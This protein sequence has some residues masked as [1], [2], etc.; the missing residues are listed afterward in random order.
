MKNEC[1]NPVI[2]KENNEYTKPIVYSK[3]IN[4]NKPKKLKK[5]CE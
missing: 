2:G 3:S 1:S 4:L 5:L